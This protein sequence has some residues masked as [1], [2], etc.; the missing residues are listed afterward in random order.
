MLEEHHPCALDGTDVEIAA[1]VAGEAEV[2]GLTTVEVEMPVRCLGA[3]AEGTPA[4]QPAT[5]SVV[6]TAAKIFKPATNVS[7]VSM[8][9]LTLRNLR[10][11]RRTERCCTAPPSSSLGRHTDQQGI[12]RNKRYIR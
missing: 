3:C 4:E 11:Y 6:E 5:A 10:C 9:R 8:T 1:G 7:R 2:V 12:V